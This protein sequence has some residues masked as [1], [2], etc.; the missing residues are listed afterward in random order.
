[1]AATWARV[2]HLGHLDPLHANHGPQYPAALVAIFP[3]RDAPRGA[4]VAHPPRPPRRH[5]RAASP[6]SEHA[7]SL[8]PNPYPGARSVGTSNPAVTIQLVATVA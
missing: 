6:A 8:D 2:C 4:L 5:T 7:A 1:M 3:T